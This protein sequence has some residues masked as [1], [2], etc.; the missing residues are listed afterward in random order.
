MGFFH[1]F[2]LTKIHSADSVDKICFFDSISHRY[3]ASI[4]DY[5]CTKCELTFFSFFKSCNLKRD[6]TAWPHPFS[7]Y[8]SEKRKHKNG[9]IHWL[10][11]ITTQART[12]CV[13]NNSLILNTFYRNN[14]RGALDYYFHLAVTLSFSKK[15]HWLTD[16]T[17]PAMSKFKFQKIHKFRQKIR[18]TTAVYIRYCSA[19]N[20]CVT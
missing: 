7:S 13:K 5:L 6:I 11:C 1:I 4:G 12:K 16:C 8:N 18:Q 15:S 10:I 3:M 17:M 2:S 14:F 20:L 9:S 19:S